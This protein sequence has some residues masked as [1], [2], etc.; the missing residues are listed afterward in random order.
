MPGSVSRCGAGPGRPPVCGAARPCGSA[1]SGCS[2]RRPGPQT[3]VSSRRPPTS[4]PGWRSRISSSRHSVGVSRTVAGRPGCQVRGQVDRASGRWLT[5]RCGGA[6]AVAAQ[7]GPQ[8]G[9]QFLHGERLGD[10]VVGARVQGAD[11]VTR[12]GPAGQHD[13]R[14]GRDQPR[15]SRIRS[16]PSTSGS[17]RSRMTASGGR[18][19]GLVQGRRPGRHGD[20]LVAARPQVDPQRTQQRGLVLDHQDGRRAAGRGVAASRDRW[21]PGAGRRGG[22]GRARPDPVL[23]RPPPCAASVSAAGPLLSAGQREL[24]VERD[25]Q[26]EHVHPR[27]AEEPERAALGDLLTSARTAAGL[28][29]RAAA[30][31]FTW[32][33]RSAGRCTG[34]GPS[35]TRSPRPAGSAR[36]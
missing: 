32:R 28:T 27:L 4:W 17:P 13:D 3:S 16:I 18:C 34:P 1:G 9:Q 26:G 12:P 35:R 14:R 36:S 7:R 10:V 29:C 24:L 31:R 30:T 22:R 5:G 25:V 15:S 6:V 2:A 20:G 19:V 23:P 8:P 11:L 21:R 33:R